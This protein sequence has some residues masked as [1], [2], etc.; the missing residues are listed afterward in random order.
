[1]TVRIREGVPPMSTVIQKVRRFTLPLSGVSEELSDAELDRLYEAGCSDAS[2]GCTAGHWFARFSREA[3]NLAEAIVT[4]VRDIEAANVEGLAVE[5]VKADE[6]MGAD[7]PDAAVVAYLDAR[8]RAR[9]LT[10]QVSEV[11]AL[12]NRFLTRRVDRLGGSLSTTSAETGMA[13]HRFSGWDP[14]NS[15]CKDCEPPVGT[16]GYRTDVVPPARPHGRLTGTHT[17]VYELHQSPLVAGCVC[18]WKEIDVIDG[19]VPP[20]GAI[21]I[22]PTGGGGP[23]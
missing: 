8:L 3:S 13:L 20:P 16:M 22:R 17:H 4:A 14:M 19:D 5:G 2:I 6:P 7:D 21:P 1:M 23:S 9:R 15:G 12:A 11:R 18:F 10:P